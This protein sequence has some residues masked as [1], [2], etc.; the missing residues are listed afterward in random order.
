MASNVSDPLFRLLVSLGLQDRPTGMSLPYPFTVLRSHPQSIT[1][2]QQ[3]YRSITTNPVINLRNHVVRTLTWVKKPRTSTHAEYEYV[4]VNI[5]IHT[6]DGAPKNTLRLD[7]IFE[8]NAC[9]DSNVL[10]STASGSTLTFAPDDL[11]RIPSPGEVQ[12][13]RMARRITFNQPEQAQPFLFF[14][15][16]GLVAIVPS[17]LGPYH[18]TDGNCYHFVS[19]IMNAASS[20][21]GP[22]IQEIERGQQPK[23]SAIG[24]CHDVNLCP[25][26]SPEQLHNLLGRFEEKRQRL[27]LLVSLFHFDTYLVFILITCV[28]SG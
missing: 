2:F 7:L 9:S 4:L 26:P 16:L 3:I 25:S 19:F 28:A 27:A 10:L 17:L 20:Y 12:G 21:M 14:H 18:L 22:R 11:V 15:F 5:D 6:Q 24:L 13:D 8:R 1:V 23:T